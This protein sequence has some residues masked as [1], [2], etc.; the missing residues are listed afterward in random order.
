[1]RILR[2]TLLVIFLFLAGAAGTAWWMI[3]RALP[4]TDGTAPLAGL[5]QPV[6]VDRDAWGV[7]HIR[8]NSLE[9]LVEAQGYVAAQDRLWQMDVLRRVGAGELSEIF[10]P[11]S[12]QLDQQFRRLGLRQVA[13]RDAANLDGERRTVLE[14]YARGVNRFID[15]HAN[16]LPVEFFALGYKP[17]PWTPADSLLVLGY[18][19][20]SLTLTWT[21]EINRE[22]VTIRVDPEHVSDM[23]SEDSPD[24]R[25]VVGSETPPAGKTRDKTLITLRESTAGIAAARTMD[26]LR[27]CQ[28]AALRTCG[29]DAQ[30][31]PK[32]V[33]GGI[34]RRDWQQ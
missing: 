31:H 20:H 3:H 12:L 19:Y 34:P 29:R 6:I 22:I 16:Q 30:K 17:K 14:A 23:Y 13:E 8:A 27:P 1:M 18:M 7:P 24:D 5:T 28:F 25:V 11:N 32:I 21:K 4:L 26:L 10:G 33:R 15:G 9:D 2:Y